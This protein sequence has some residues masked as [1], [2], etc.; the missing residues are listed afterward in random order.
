MAKHCDLTLGDVIKGANIISLV[1]QNTANPSFL[2]LSSS[3]QEEGL[4][5]DLFF[6]Q[7]ATNSRLKCY[8]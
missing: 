2:L 1:S 4:T 3:K 6:F 8:K 7:E 5:K